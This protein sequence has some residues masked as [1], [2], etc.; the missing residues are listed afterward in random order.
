MKVADRRRLRRARMAALGLA[1]ALGTPTAPVSAL[2]VTRELGALQA[3]DYLSGVWSLGVRSGLT[4]AEI[5]QAV[6]QRQVVRTWPMRGTIHFVPA[7][8]ARWMSRLLAGRVI[9][10]LRARYEQLSI[11]EREIGTAAGVFAE[12]LTE[13]VRRPDVIALLEAAG[14]DP[15]GQRAYHLVGHHCM[16]GLLCQGPMIGKQPSFV[17]IDSWV[18]AS[19]EPTR[20]EGLATVVER[21]LRGH[22]PVTE[23]DVAGWLAHPLGLAREALAL[24]GDRVLREELDGETWLTH[25]DVPRR[26]AGPTGVHLLPQWDEFLLG[27]RSRD[28]TLPDEHLARVVP[29]RNMVFQPT[30]VI[31]GEVAGTWKRQESASGV[32]VEVSPFSPLTT[33]ARR[34]LEA[35]SAAYGQ[36]LGRAVELRV[37]EP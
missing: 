32:R 35:S 16:T 22:G 3:Q 6:Q 13:P 25:A 34:G 5:E 27:Y 7:E 20:E 21:Y 33:T 2:S 36:F 17:L 1:P 26:A 8:D 31:D 37:T 4:K 15:S 12:H 19:R 28:L 24:L 14:I 30:L 18:P 29:G 10:S 23:K 9:G 11:T